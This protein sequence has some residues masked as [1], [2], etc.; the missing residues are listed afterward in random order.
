MLVGHHDLGSLADVHT[1]QGVQLA[2]FDEWLLLAID[3]NR[4]IENA[5]LLAIEREEAVSGNM[6][7]PV[8]RLD[9]INLPTERCWALL[10]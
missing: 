8:L 5:K 7:E 9:A 1:A 10:A 6:P 3:R 2:T 4:T